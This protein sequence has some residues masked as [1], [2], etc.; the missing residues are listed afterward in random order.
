MKAHGLAARGRGPIEPRQQ[1]RN[2]PVAAES[3]RRAAAQTEA[4]SAWHTLPR[5]HSAAHVVACMRP[6]AD[7]SIVGKRHQGHHDRSSSR[8]A[9][10]CRRSPGASVGC[11][12]CGRPLRFSPQARPA[13][14]AM[15]GS[16]A[17]SSTPAAS[18]AAAALF[19]AFSFAPSFFGMVTQRA[20]V[21]SPKIERGRTQNF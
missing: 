15:G 3:T 16:R 7:P 4:K 18:A 20:P 13:A 19:A 6:A 8:S 5:W 12:D 21:A 2:Q 1:R 9:C 14:P 10:V 11:G 17:H